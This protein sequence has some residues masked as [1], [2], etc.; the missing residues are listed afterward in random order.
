MGAIHVHEFMTLDGIIDAPIWTIDY[1]FH[2]SM[3]EAIPDV[4]LPPWVTAP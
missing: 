2:P 3:G 1:G 4:E